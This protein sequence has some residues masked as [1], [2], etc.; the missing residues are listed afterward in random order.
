MLEEDGGLAFTVLP[1]CR[2]GLGGLEW[3]LRDAF[4]IF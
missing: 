3:T 2:L 4:K 1:L